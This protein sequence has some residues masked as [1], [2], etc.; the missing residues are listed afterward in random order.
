MSSRAFAHNPA[1]LLHI[2]PYLRERGISPLEIFRRAGISPSMLLEAN[3]WVPRDLCFVLGEQVTAVVDDGFTG[4]KIGQR[5][6]LTELGAW[7]SAVIAAQNLREACTVAANGIGL[8]HGGSDLRLLTFRRHAQLRFS[9]RGKL[10][11]NPVQHLLSCLV[12]LRKIAL[13]AGA[14]EAV[15][16]HLSMPYSRGADQLEETHGPVLEFGCAHDAIV[17]DR[18]VMDQPLTDAVGSNNSV[19]PAETAAAIGA[20]VKQLLPYGHITIDK[21]AARQR[22]SVRTLQRRLRD[23]GFSF[24]EIVDD[25]R[26]T[27]AISHMFAR[28]HSSMEIA[29]LLG[30]SD[31]AH[32]TRAF[33][34]WTGLSPREYASA[35]R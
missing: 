10:P 24:E 28:E 17:I 12:I 1:T 34:R 21:V 26:R 31:Q 16:V 2:A 9:F 33:K 30:Y 13:L 27:E 22:L 11:T 18:E 4:A 32:F 25:V 15:S 14:P 6:R 20:L 35:Y 3:G 5:Y 23:W 7:G 29:F 8:L 19:E